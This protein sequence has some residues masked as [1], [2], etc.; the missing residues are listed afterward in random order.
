M[1]KIIILAF[2]I[3]INSLSY[4][5]IY[6][7]IA[8][9]VQSVPIAFAN[10]IALNSNNELIT[11]VITNEDGE[12]ELV[13]NSKDPFSIVI[14]FIGNEDWKKEISEIGDINLGVITLQESN[15]ELDEVVIT[16]ERPTIKRKVD[17]LIFNIEKSVIASGGDAVDVLKK[18]PGVRVDEDN[19]GLIGKSSVRIL[20]NDRLTPLTGEDLSN[21]LRSLSSEDI[22]K[23]EVIT[24]PPAKYEA[25]GN[26]GLIN[27][28][29]KKV[30]RD[31]FGG[32]IRTT[33]KQTTYPSAFLGGGITYQKD[34]WSLFSNINS[35]DG[36]IEVT[37]TN[38][39]FYPAQKWDTDTKIR[40][41]TKFV[42]GRAGVDYDIT[43]N[44]SIGIQYIGTT[45]RPDNE[46]RTAT[47]ILNNTNSLDSLLLTNANSQRKTYYHSLNGHFKTVLDSIGKSI[48][49]DVDY[50][51]YENSLDRIN[52]TNSFLPN[53]DIINN[54]TEVF[55]NKSNQ[56]IETFTSGINF[57]WPTNF[58]NLEFGGKLSF[59]KNNSDV[60]AFNFQDNIFI[61][62]PSQSNTFKYLEN[63]QAVYASASKSL[64]KWDFKL[65]ARLEFT[66]TEGNSITL[67][68]VN[69]NNY[70]KLFPTAYITY[71]PNENNSW[72]LNYG[73]RINRPSYSSLNPFRWYSNPYSYTEGNPFLQPSF[74]D[75][76][77]LSHL[78]KN[79]LNTS[80]YVSITEDGSDQVTLTDS[81]TNIQ[82]TVR[83]NFLEEYVL[84]LSQTYTFSGVKWFESYLQYDLGF[85]KI[86]SNIPNTIDEQD[87][88]NFYFSVDNSFYF[89][90]K[91]TLLGELNF[92]YSA[93]GVSGVDNIT[94][95]YASDIGFKW[96][97]FEK[98]FQISFVASD[99]FRTNENTIKSVVND[100]RQEY[101]NYYDNRRFRISMV[102][103]FGNKNLRSKRKQFSN[104]EERRRTD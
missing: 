20:I 76:F 56:D 5:Q 25:E 18:T 82:A 92:W 72:S 14:S 94:E 53:G 6:Q 35:G 73:K 77:E 95:S 91:K 58:S 86:K 32:N 16:A 38:K 39:I 24:N 65:G 28:V 63:T 69:K 10:V 90:S 9:D 40:Y 89:N 61:I 42:S 67:N 52:S 43:D 97:L 3:S 34:K 104:E 51:T 55:Q 4:A 70:T 2:L 98:Q 8:K 21:Y 71:N 54:S 29:L 15:N 47:N 88:F 66:Q 96:L 48:T 19:I 7:G 26:S 23:I 45:S 79:N 44:T 27:I 13:V 36:S 68:Q 93:P 101:R 22:S 60:G 46:E 64:N 1:K 41:F 37:E 80:F 12:F 31:Y 11:G 102:Y 30:K 84:G 57:E 50:F 81:D 17:R 99:I 78:F 85:S 49:I 62:D 59:I 103:R 33:Y 74:I 87:G 75:N 100:I 83:K